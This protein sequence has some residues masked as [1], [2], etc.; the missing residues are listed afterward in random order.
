M[1][2][3]STSLLSCSI[4]FSVYLIHF[5]PCFFLLYPGLRTGLFISLQQWISSWWSMGKGRYD[6]I[7]NEAIQQEAREDGAGPGPDLGQTSATCYYVISTAADCRS[8]GDL[9]HLKQLSNRGFDSA[10]AV[11]A[12]QV[13]QTHCLS[14]VKHPT[15]CLVF[16]NRGHKGNRPMAGESVLKYVF[17][18][19]S[20][21]VCGLPRPSQCA[22][23]NL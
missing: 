11:G 23:S 5:T 3:L 20:S 8:S 21:F 7:P 19:I 17:R 13:K 16:S 1:L 18:S 4:F 12:K 2:G 9:Q 10:M 22:L 6:V 15:S 14:L